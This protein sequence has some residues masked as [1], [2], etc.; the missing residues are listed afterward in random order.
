MQEVVNHRICVP[1]LSLCRLE[2]QY[3]LLLTGPSLLPFN[4]NT[5]LK[6]TDTELLH[7]SIPSEG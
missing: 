7:W 5:A 1:E 6:M 3:T 4:Y 2:Y